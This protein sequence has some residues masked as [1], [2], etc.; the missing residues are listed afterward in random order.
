MNEIDRIR[1]LD[2]EVFEELQEYFPKTTTSN[3]KKEFPVTWH[4]IGM[5]DTGSTFIKNS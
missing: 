5:F 3:F 1:D 4:L 2:N